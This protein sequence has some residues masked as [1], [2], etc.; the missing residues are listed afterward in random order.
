AWDFDLLGLGDAHLVVTTGVDPDESLAWHDA[1]VP[2]VD[3]EPLDLVRAADRIRRRREVVLRGAAT[4]ALYTGI[5][6]IAQPGYVDTSVP[7]HP[8]RAVADAKAVIPTDGVVV[9][10]PGVA[11]LW[12]ARTFPTSVLGSVVVP[13]TRAP[14]V[15]AALAYA[16]STR[17]RPA[18]AVTTSPLDPVTDA[19]AALARADGTSFVLDAWEPDAPVG[20]IHEH[21]QVLADGFAR[22]GVARVRTPV[23]LHRTADLVEVAGPVVAWGGL[24]P[25][26]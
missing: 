7:L 21:T 12:F 11:G 5:A 15:A 17:G 16:A 2:V 20:P 6:A 24:D 14:G 4:N 9:V 25:E 3:I 18:L 13:A 1:L 26:E 10:D 23:A 22:G 19:I 8:A